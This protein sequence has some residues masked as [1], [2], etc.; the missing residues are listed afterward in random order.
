MAQLAGYNKQR[1]SVVVYGGSAV[2]G[3]T[4]LP[5]LI[6]PYG[7]VTVTGAYIIPSAAVTADGTNY[8]TATLINAATTGTATTAI[9]TAGGTA[10]VPVTPNAF[11]VNTAADELTAGQ[12]L[13]VRIVK[14]G[15]IAE[16]E[17]SV[18]VEYVGGKG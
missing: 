6:A 15:T 10:G 16:R 11:T 7:G 5:I 18:V 4:T 1:T 9:G 12:W 14:S 2:A 13:A 3:T 17:Y 8:V